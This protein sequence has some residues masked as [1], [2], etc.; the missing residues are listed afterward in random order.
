MG[1]SAAPAAPANKRPVITH[2]AIGKRLILI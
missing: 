1:W 2:A